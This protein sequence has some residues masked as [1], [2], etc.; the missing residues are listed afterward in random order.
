MDRY[1]TIMGDVIHHARLNSDGYVTLFLE[2]SMT[3]K[4]NPFWFKVVA[5]TSTLL[6]DEALAF[7]FA[8]NGPSSVGEIFPM[9]R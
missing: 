2:G 4:A 6:L 5:G 9:E 1:E 3:Q 8:K 7:V